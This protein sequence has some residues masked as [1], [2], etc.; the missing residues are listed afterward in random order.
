MVKR[1]E[2]MLLN[3][4]NKFLSDDFINKQAPDYYKRRVEE[5]KSEINEKEFRITV[6][7][8]FSSGKST[9]INALIGK[10]ILSHALTETTAAIT[11]I[12]N[13]PK[14]NSKEDKIIINFNDI[15]KKSQ[16]FDLKKYPNA[17]KD[18]ATTQSEVADVVQEIKS[19]EIYVNFRNIN[20]KVVFID[21]PGLNGVADGHRDLTMQEIKKAHASICLFQLRGVSASHEFLNI[22][23][24][25]QNSMLFVM[26]FID[27][28][29]GV[30]G[31]NPDDKLQ[32]FQNQLKQVLNIHDK[33]DQIKL[34]VFGISAL[35]A[36]VYKDQ[37]IKRIYQDDE[38][39]LTSEDKIKAWQE[40]RFE[41]FEEHL[42]KNVIEGDKNKIFYENIKRKFK[43]NIIDLKEQ[44]EAEMEIAVTTTQ[45]K[46]VEEIQSRLDKFDQMFTKNLSK[47]ERFIESRQFEL[48]R[49]L[50][51][52]IKSD[53]NNIENGIYQQLNKETFHSIQEAL[54]ENK[55]GGLLQNKIISAKVVYNRYLENI[56]EEIYQSAI[57]R[58]KEYQPTIKINAKGIPVI[59]NDIVTD[60]GEAQ[61]S[62]EM[63]KLKSEKEIFKSSKEKNV[64]EKNKICEEENRVNKTRD[65]IKQKVKKLQQ[66]LN[67]ERSRLG[68]EPRV[69]TREIEETIYVERASL[70]IFRLFGSSHKEK[71]VTKTVEDTA[72]RDNWRKK[73]Q[74]LKIKYANK[75]VIERKELDEL[76]RRITN[77]KNRRVQNEA[78]IKRLEEK[79]K[80]KE[81]IIKRKQ[82]DFQE[83][84]SKA[85][86]EYVNIQKKQISEK[87]YTVLNTEN[88]RIYLQLRE[89]IKK[90]IESNIKKIKFNVREYY[91]KLLN[92]YKRKLN[93]LKKD[94]DSN[95]EGQAKFIKDIEKTY[96]KLEKL[97][98]NT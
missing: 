77:L 89:S 64:K 32:D 23:S 96:K 21:T 57:L 25:Y 53:L 35:K 7:G 6:I 47:I 50:K 59:E 58:V 84:M 22:V 51:K 78:Q 46:K 17:L 36:L 97:L 70:S 85:K 24:K 12:H 3:K 43:Q 95:N 86:K 40:S 54:N 37:T 42:W 74:Q 87:V 38:I 45:N 60:F 14:G 69:E 81:D 55:Y 8:E 56:I 88:G 2:I 67:N 65:I 29:K 61:F 9:F 30:E 82:E 41:V 20:E 33:D 1:N 18:F 28:I 66:E 63:K 49:D 16:E 62:S 71:T 68:S 48:E 83:I 72:K 39:D 91:E 11:Y 52:K 98:N 34:K 92:E 15:N 75:D 73:Q 93:L 4:I 90:N 13:V 31:E 26:N 19:V 79:I 27:E 80:D 94:N 76:N 5:L 44:L 10:D